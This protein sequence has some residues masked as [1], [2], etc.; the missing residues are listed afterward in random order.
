MILT[1]PKQAASPSCHQASFISVLLSFWCCFQ[2][3]R[4]IS[5]Y[6][7]NVNQQKIQSWPIHVMWNEKSLNLESFQ[8][9]PRSCITSSLSSHSNNH[10][11]LCSQLD[12]HQNVLK[13]VK[14]LCILTHRHSQC[15]R[16]AYPWKILFSVLGL[17]GNRTLTSHQVHH[18][19]RPPQLS[20]HRSLVLTLPR[21][22]PFEGKGGTS[23]IWVSLARSLGW[24]DQVN[25][26]GIQKN[27]C[28]SLFWYL[29]SQSCQK[30]T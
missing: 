30:Y 14:I 23:R 8:G 12:L 20:L 24:A 10:S 9:S 6:I 18:R 4:N 21:N 15:W 26:H 7:S 27:E 29:V 11:S 22:L 16:S 28:P 13:R 3:L 2:H 25:N 5:S 19:L 1:S 17:V